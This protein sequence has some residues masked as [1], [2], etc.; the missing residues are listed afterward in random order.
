MGTE[1]HAE[2]RI[3]SVTSNY[4]KLARDIN[5]I[6]NVVKD[7]YDEIIDSG[8]CESIERCSNFLKKMNQDELDLL[9][10]KEKSEKAIED[11]KNKYEEERLYNIS[12]IEETNAK[13]QK[14]RFEVEDTLGNFLNTG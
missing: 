3:N 9:H 13:I 6:I 5:M 11:L 12:T 1:D 10:S 7:A 4:D 2:F 14:L 8:T